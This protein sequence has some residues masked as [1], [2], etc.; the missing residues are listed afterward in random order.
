M[1]FKLHNCTSLKIKKNIKTNN[2]NPETTG[3][4]KTYGNY[5]CCR[6]FMR[7]NINCHDFIV[8]STHKLQTNKTLLLK[9]QINDSYKIPGKI[10][11]S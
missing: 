5:V 1:G 7:S 8:V 11:T 4:Q 6:D 2:L 9:T 10:I 3:S